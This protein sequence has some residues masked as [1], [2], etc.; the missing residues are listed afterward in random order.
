MIGNQCQMRFRAT[1]NACGMPSD[2]CRGNVGRKIPVD[3]D[4]QALPECILPGLK[5]AFGL[6][7]HICN[8]ML[9]LCTF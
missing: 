9:S 2:A 6:A 5:N 4:V 1:K 7:F 8:A 3:M